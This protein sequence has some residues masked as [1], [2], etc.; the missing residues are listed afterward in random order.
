MTATSPQ[1]APASLS[2]LR[3]TYSAAWLA[4][5]QDGTP[6][7]RWDAA[8]ALHAAGLA[9]YRACWRAAEGLPVVDVA[10][11]FGSC[12]P[13]RIDL[14]W[15]TLFWMPAPPTPTPAPV[16][17]LLGVERKHDRPVAVTYTL[18]HLYGA[19][20]LE[21][22]CFAPAVRTATVRRGLQPASEKDRIR[23]L[24][25]LLRGT[26]ATAPAA[27]Y[28]GDAAVVKCAW[29]FIQAGAGRREPRLPGG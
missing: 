6:D 20:D 14:D 18:R 28:P 5:R 4:A 29:D 19:A 3:D 24:R 23:N 25:A 7:A 17:V 12:E 11:P 15:A 13:S 27:P 8:I 9:L 26:A 22:V 2:A 1:G 10:A 21:G 16:Y